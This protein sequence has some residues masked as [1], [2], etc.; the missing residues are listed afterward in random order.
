MDI[1]A[2]SHVGNR[3]SDASVAA[4]YAGSM[5]KA[6]LMDLQ[7]VSVASTLSPAPSV[8]TASKATYVML[9]AQ[10]TV[11]LE[12]TGLD[13]D[14]GTS[15]PWSKIKLDKNPDVVGRHIGPGLLLPDITVVAGYNDNLTFE[16][17]DSIGS[18]Y[19]KIQPHATYT[20]GGKIHKFAI[21][22]FI[23]AGYF[24]ATGG[25]DNYFDNRLVATIDYNPTRRIF[26]SAFAEYKDSHDGRGQSRAEAGTGTT[27][28][29]LDEWHLWGM[30]GEFA[31]GAAGARGRLEF[32]AGYANKR[33]DT[34]RLFTFTRD[35]DDYSASGRFL[36]R[37][38]PK[39]SVLIE[40][41]ATQHDY[42]RDAAGIP[43][44]DGM[45]TSFLTGVTWQ[46][47]Y[48]TTG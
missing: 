23:D 6:G 13:T 31:Y 36:Y 29:S 32:D 18:F 35:L 48:K 15:D 41:R 16:N 20:M 42:A 44:L 12:S 5:Q 17:N 26:A 1:S 2:I 45:T 39:T 19:T 33:Y 22:Y 4:P 46:A 25:K 40:S 14:T 34:N 11:G 28:T 30:G 9:A 10:D 27:Q 37:V 21:D 47:T 3:I 38:R 43:S 7:S 8:D 24:E